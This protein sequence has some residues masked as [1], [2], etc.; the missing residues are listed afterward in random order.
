MITTGEL[1]KGIVLNLDGELVRVTDFQHVKLGRGS[2]FVR[3]TL[4]NLRTGA[5]TQ[6]TFQAGSTFEDVRLE[7]RRVQFLYRDGDEFHF[8]DLDTYEQPVLTADMLGDAVYYIKENDVVDLLIYDSEPVSVELPTAVEL[9]VVQTEPGVKGDT[10]TGA[11]KP[12]T[13]ETGLVVTVPLFVDIGDIVK[14][15]TRTGEYIERVSR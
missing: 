5:I 13:L 11:T 8:M 10:A 15:D 9:R 12:A 4:K 3:L 7:R 2:A 14:V 1:R 6:R